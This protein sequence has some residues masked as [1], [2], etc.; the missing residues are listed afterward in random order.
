M[1]AGGAFE[2]D[3]GLCVQALKV[4]GIALFGAFVPWSGRCRLQAASGVAQQFGLDASATAS[5]LT[6]ST[7]PPPSWT[8]CRA[9]FLE[10][11]SR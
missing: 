4:G 2:R 11:A 8:R 7:V 10:E 6:N 9:S 5:C 1:S 3:F